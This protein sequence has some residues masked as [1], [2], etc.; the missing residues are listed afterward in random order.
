MAS[1]S[2]VVHTLGIL[3]EDAGYKQAIRD[4]DLLGLLGAFTGSRGGGNPLRERGRREKSYEGM[5]RDSG[6]A[7]PL[8]TPVTLTKCSRDRAG[9]DDEYAVFQGEETFHLHLCGGRF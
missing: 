1:S 3:L 9:Y 2:A 8:W 4:G 5:N 6:G 7:L